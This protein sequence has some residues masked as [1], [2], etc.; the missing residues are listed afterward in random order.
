MPVYPSGGSSTLPSDFRPETYGAQ[1]NG[2]SDDTNGLQSAIN[3]AASANGRVLLSNKT[4]AFTALSVPSFVKIQGAGV[5]GVYDT[6]ASGIGNFTPGLAPWLKGSVLK[7]M[8]TGNAAAITITGE[9]SAVDL[10]DFGLTWNTLFATTGHGISANPGSNKNGLSNSEWRNVHVFG[11][12]GNSYGFDIANA[13]Q[14]DYFHLRNWGGG[15]LRFSQDLGSQYGNSSFF[16]CMTKTF[17]RGS[18]HGTYLRSVAGNATR[19]SFYGSECNALDA[20]AAYPARAPF[21]T[22]LAPNAAQ[23]LFK[24]DTGAVRGTSFVGCAWD[25]GNNAAIGMPVFGGSTL[26]GG[27]FIDPGSWFTVGQSYENLSINTWAAPG[28][29]GNGILPMNINQMSTITGNLT[30][31]ATTNFWFRRADATTGNITVTL[32]AANLTKG[33]QFLVKKVDASANT[34]TVSRAGADTIDGATTVVLSAQ[35]QKVSVMSNG[36]SWDVVGQ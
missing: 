36:T 28:D 31:T 34:V 10:A 24:A 2:T 35:W 6:F 13:A 19:L 3:A 11:T 16:G 27:Q 17:V 4:Y 33:R 30:L 21:N 7:C 22:L 5:F 23:N 14:C 18:A 12:D 15:L 9:S 1:G 8:Q 29:S 25:V 20:A 26:H 32:P